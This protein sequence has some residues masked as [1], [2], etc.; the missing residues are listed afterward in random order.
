MDLLEMGE[1]ELY[2]E[3][4]LP[5]KVEALIRRAADTYGE[6]QSEQMLLKAYDIEPH[7]PVVH[8]ALYRYYF[9]RHR[10]DNALAIAE[11]TLED[12]GRGLGFDGHWSDAT[13]GLLGA[14][15]QNMAKVRY[16]LLALKAAGLICLRMGYSDAG[17][18]R[19]QK[20]IEMDGED[21]LGVRALLQ[22]IK[23]QVVSSQAVQ[24]EQ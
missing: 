4:A 21:R 1:Q 20:V 8:V 9:Y 13:L 6:P 14:S 3:R 10:L 2:F 24:A 18:I 7:H 11:R 17:R 15:A 22:V 23:P 19:L 12:T 16:Y 5:E